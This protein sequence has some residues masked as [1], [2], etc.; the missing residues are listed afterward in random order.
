MKFMLY[1]CGAK[2][3]CCQMSCSRPSCLC[4]S[5]TKLA[6]GLT[7][8][9]LE[10]HKLN[11]ALESVFKACKQ[12]YLS[13]PSIT[14]AHI[15]QHILPDLLWQ[16]SLLHLKPSMLHMSQLQHATQDR[17]DFVEW[18]H[19]LAATVSLCLS[20]MHTL[21]TVSECIDIVLLAN[22][23]TI[24]RRPSCML[25]VHAASKFYCCHCF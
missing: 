1:N 16:M 12:H 7:G 25:P 19:T 10:K 23:N 24:K 22:V 8:Q 13:D 3:A 15:S 2:S 14:G 9:D 21:Q 20:S 4:M 17:L 11:A 18:L 5:A 6:T